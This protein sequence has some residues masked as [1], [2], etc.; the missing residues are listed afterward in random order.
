MGEEKIVRSTTIAKLKK[1]GIT[2]N[3]RDF[4]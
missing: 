2:C 3:T 4:H 1:D